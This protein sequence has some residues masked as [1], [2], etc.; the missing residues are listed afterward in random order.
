MLKFEVLVTVTFLL[1]WKFPF[2]LYK[3]T[4]YFRY[5]NRFQMWCL[6]SYRC[7]IRYKRLLLLSDIFRFPWSS[8][9]VGLYFYNNSCCFCSGSHWPFWWLNQ[10]NVTNYKCLPILAAITFLEPEFFWVFLVVAIFSNLCTKY[11]VFKLWN[12][13]FLFV[14]ENWLNNSTMKWAI[15]KH[16]TCL[17]YQVFTFWLIAY[18]S[19]NNLHVIFHTRVINNITCYLLWITMK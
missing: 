15:Y 6:A 2:L 8:L 12:C 1:C 16:L 4:E 9:W 13:T 11:F 7:W 5:T 14:I 3:L 18:P 19:C 17:A 10:N